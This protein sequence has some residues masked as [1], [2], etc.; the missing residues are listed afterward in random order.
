M[1]AEGVS[2]GQVSCRYSEDLGEDLP[3]REVMAEG[4]MVGSRRTQI[5]RADAWSTVGTDW[6]EHGGDVMAASGQGVESTPRTVIA[7]CRTIR[8]PTKRV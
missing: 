8:L 1:G 5:G 3:L 6:V 4:A 7:P 2:T